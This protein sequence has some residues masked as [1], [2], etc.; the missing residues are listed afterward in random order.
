[1][2]TGNLLLGTATGSARL[3]VRGSGT[4]TSTTTFLLQNS[5]GTQLGY[6]DDSG[7]WQIGQGTNSGYALEVSGST[8]ITSASGGYKLT[9]KTTGGGNGAGLLVDQNGYTMFDV[10]A[11]DVYMRNFP[12][13]TAKLDFW[14][15]NN[16][17]G[18]T[19]VLFAQ[20]SQYH[21]S[22]NSPDNYKIPIVKFPDAT[23]PIIM[24]NIATSAI[25]GY[26]T[27][28][29]AFYASASLGASQRIVSTVSAIANNDT[30]IGLDILPTFSTGSYTGVTSLALRVSGSATISSILTL[31]PQDPLPSGVP[32]GSFAVS[33]SAPPKPY[34]YDGTTWNALY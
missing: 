1:M 26:L 24:G 3:T 28:G 13:N 7:R 6:V 10:N 9:L 12:S 21:V 33:S 19:N 5:N 32:T 18:P 31:T 2:Y 27:V 17:G 8:Q 14:C 15:W 4:T 11:S 30:L 34:F 23:V 29:G 20:N 25:R 22:L 16:Y